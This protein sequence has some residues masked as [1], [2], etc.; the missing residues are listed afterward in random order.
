LLLAG[1]FAAIQR[2]RSGAAGWGLMPP[3]STP[4][5][6]LVVAAGVVA[7]WLAVSVTSGA[8]ASR[9]FAVL[10]VLGLMGARLLTGIDPKVALTAVVGMALALAAAAGL[11]TDAPG[12]A[13]YIAAAAIAAGVSVLRVAEPHAA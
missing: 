6:I 8:G 1:A 7:L 10:A 13:P 11:A 2:Q 5:L 4:R 9:R 12:P 3:G